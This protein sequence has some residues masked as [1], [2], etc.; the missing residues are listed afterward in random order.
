MKVGSWALVGI[1]LA[2]CVGLP[3]NAAVL[4]TSALK[5]GRIVISVTGDIAEGD[6][7][8][9]KAIVKAPMTL[10]SLLVLFD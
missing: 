3:A 9:F 6:T 8:A 10:A 4:K 1:T 5:D 7:D 2:I